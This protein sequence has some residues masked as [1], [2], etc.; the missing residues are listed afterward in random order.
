MMTNDE[1]RAIVDAHGKWLRGESGGKRADLA[2]A[3]L[4]G[5]N[6]AGAN[7]AGANLMRAELTGANL[8]GANLASANLT[9]AKLPHFLIVPQQGAF[10]AWKKTTDGVAKLEIPA[11]ARRCNSRVGRK[12]RAE[13]V[14]TLAINDD[15][16]PGKSARGLYSVTTIYTVGEITRPDSYDDDTRV[17]CTHGIHFF[18]TREE[19]EEWS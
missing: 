2:N 17:E 1:L 15:T 14:R 3:D 13:F 4:A 19:A 6:L 8:A 10:I 7:L 11:D 5:A 12:C 16:T 18:I 9:D